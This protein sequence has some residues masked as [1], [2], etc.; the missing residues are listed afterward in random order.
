MDSR[1]HG[2]DKKGR[3]SLRC[4]AANKT[5]PYNLRFT[6]YE[7]QLIDEVVMKVR[8]KLQTRWEDKVLRPG[9]TAEIESN[10]ARRWID[11]GIAEPAA[12]VPIPVEEPDAAETVSPIK[13]GTELED[14]KYNELRKI[15]SEKNITVPKGTKK[16]EL[17]VLIRESAFA[18]DNASADK[19]RADVKP[20]PTDEKKTA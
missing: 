19:G 2:N 4:N 16:P 13:S 6:K 14:L 17:I 20:A 18:F 9:D 3:C 11:R 12:S 10:T 15:A 5:C 7:I 1:F 8:M